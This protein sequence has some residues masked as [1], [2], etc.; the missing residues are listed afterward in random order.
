MSVPLNILCKIRYS[1]DWVSKKKY[2]WVFWE[3]DCIS[4]L[5]SPS[6]TIH[7]VNFHQGQKDLQKHKKVCLT[8]TESQTD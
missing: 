2:N 3:C 4:G 5:G 6:K 7:H 8:F 1:S